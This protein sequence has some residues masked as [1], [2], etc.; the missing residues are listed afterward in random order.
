MV[1]PDQCDK[2]GRF[3]IVAATF[4]SN[5]SPT[6]VSF[7]VTRSL[8]KPKIGQFNNLTRVVLI[9]RRQLGHFFTK[10]GVLFLETFGHTDH[11]P[12]R[13]I[14]VNNETREAN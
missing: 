13:A 9:T 10:L 6:W 5:Q 12:N 4:E 7:R 11:P 14:A 3:V 2:N 1:E 8:H